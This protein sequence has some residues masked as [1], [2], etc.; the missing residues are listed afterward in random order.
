M[1]TGC[2][3]TSKSSNDHQQISLFSFKFSKNHSKEQKGKT[4]AILTNVMSDH[5]L[6][7]AAAPFPFQVLPRPPPHSNRFIST[8]VSHWL[9]AHFQEDKIILAVGRGNLWQH[10][11]CYRR[12][13]LAQTAFPVR[14]VTTSTRAV[15]NS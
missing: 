5:L 13:H 14:P 9:Y 2:I 10:P 12:Q 15:I 3:F 7:G 4:R 6:F 8:L 1:A 11:M